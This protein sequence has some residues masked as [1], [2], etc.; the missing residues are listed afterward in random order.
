M[1]LKGAVV[2]SGKIGPTGKVEWGI[3]SSNA[4]H[5]RGQLPEGDGGVVFKFPLASP[6]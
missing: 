2:G 4:R 1:V 5:M 6:I 3:V